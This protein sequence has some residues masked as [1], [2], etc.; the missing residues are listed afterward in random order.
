MPIPLVRT[1]GRW[2]FDGAAGALE[3]LSRRIGANELRTINVMRG[4]VVAQTEYAATAH[5]GVAA[6]VYARKLRS[7]AGKRNGL[8]WEPGAGEPP[9]PAGP[10]L[11]SATAEGYTPAG[12]RVP[13][14]GYLFRLLLAQGPAADGGAH[15]YAENGRLTRGFGLL[16]WPVSYGQSGVMTFMVN[17]DGVVWQRDLGEDTTLLAERIRA[18]NPDAGWTP[19][20]A[21]ASRPE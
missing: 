14:H 20:P 10:L 7:D 21:E 5:D 8:Y 15:D 13:Y 3:L 9:S 19:L 17:Q 18:F 11:A 6:G 4:F 12:E 1:E 16:A 2:H